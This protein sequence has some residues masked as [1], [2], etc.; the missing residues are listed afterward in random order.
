MTWK[1]FVLG[2]FKQIDQVI[3]QYGLDRITG[4]DIFR[5]TH[6]L[7]HLRDKFNAKGEL[8]FTQTEI[9]TAI[10]HTRFAIANVLLFFDA[11]LSNFKY[12]KTQYGIVA[13][14]RTRNLID[15][16]FF[17]FVDDTFMR[18]YGYWN[19]I[20]NLLNLFFEVEKDEAKVYFPQVI[21]QLPPDVHADRNYKSLITFKDSDYKKMN[22]KRRKIVHRF[23]SSRSYF[24]Y[25]HKHI[26]DEKKLKKLQKERDEL[27]D[28]FL[29]CYNRMIQGLNETV[30]LINFNIQ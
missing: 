29:K 5:K 15:S 14:M 26:T 11:G 13:K 2:Y 12:Q 7:S 30:D 28:Y 22:N 18:L 27:P 25:W 16:R 1:D 17:F 9:D 23:S 19:R 6:Q 24:S 4:Q 3:V 21:E 10:M 8:F 20:A